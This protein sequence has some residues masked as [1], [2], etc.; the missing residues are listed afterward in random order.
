M[1]NRDNQSQH[2]WAFLPRG[3]NIPVK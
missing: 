3:E 1:T 2:I